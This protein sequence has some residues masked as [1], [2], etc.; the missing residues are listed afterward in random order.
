[1]SIAGGPKLDAPNGERCGFEDL[2][3]IRLA[4]LVVYHFDDFLKEL[5]AVHL[6]YVRRF[7]PPE[8]VILGAALR[9]KPEQQAWLAAQPGLQLRELGP[10]P[11]GFSEEHNCALDRLAKIAFAEGATHVAAMHQ[12]SFPVRSDWFVRLLTDL[13]AETPFAVAERRAYNACMVWGR[14][15]QAHEPTMLPS[16]ALCELAT[17]GLTAARPDLHFKDGGIGHLLLAHSL[18]LRWRALR[19]TAPDILDGMVLHL[20]G[21]T[22]IAHAESVW[23]GDTSLAARLR[24]ISSPV[25]HYFPQSLR[26]RVGRLVGV[27]AIPKPQKSIGGDGSAQ[28][29]RKQISRLVADPQAYVDAALHEPLWT[30]AMWANQRPPGRGGT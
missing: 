7:T 27:R 28:E 20:T 11:V 26:N 6:D 2:V 24:S 16:E 3:D 8:T 14:D 4:V 25:L 12:D 1:M 23:R 17:Q 19:H 22:R 10:L 18:G 21:S 29:K 15:W 9:L 30:E 13:D 5:V